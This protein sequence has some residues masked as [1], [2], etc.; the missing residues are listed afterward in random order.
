MPFFVEILNSLLCGHKMFLGVS[1]NLLND[2]DCCRMCPIVLFSIYFNLKLEFLFYI[3]IFGMSN[4]FYE[5]M[6]SLLD[7]LT[8]CIKKL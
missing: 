5:S 3:F 4:I 7:L 8:F 1:Y 6:C 2:K